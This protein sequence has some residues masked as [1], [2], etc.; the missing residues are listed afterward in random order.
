M[1]TQPP[2]IISKALEANFQQTASTVEISPRW[3]PLQEV[4]ARYQGLASRLEHLLY[5]IS[6][7]YRN[8]Q[9]IISELRPFVLKNISHYLS[10]EQGPDC[11]ALFSSIFLDAL[12][13]SRKNSKVVSQTVE[14]L[15]A[16]ADKLISSLTPQTLPRYG[17]ALNAF[18]EQLVRLDEMDSG[19]MMQMVQ[20]HHPLKKMAEQ[21]ISLQAVLDFAVQPSGFSIARQNHM[22]SVELLNPSAI[23]FRPA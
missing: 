6:H 12:K 5:E 9:L 13:D 22:V 7:P 14:A 20:G 1:P 2:P 4:V 3:R 16:Y 19:V 18:F 10:H 8:W 11:F 21:L 15:L 17:G 23:F